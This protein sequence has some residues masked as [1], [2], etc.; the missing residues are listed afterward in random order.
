MKKK[1]G[2]SFLALALL[3]FG[4]LSIKAQS[5][6][7]FSA[8]TMVVE[9]NELFSAHVRVTGFEQIVGA[10]YS[11][12]W[13]PAVLRFL[14]VENLA[15][16][17]T[18][19]DN[20][21]TSNAEAGI[22]SF[23]WYDAAL[24]GMTLTDSTIL[25]SIRFEAVGA[26]STSTGIAFTNMPTVKEVVDM[27]FM[28]ISAGFIDGTVSI[29]GPSAANDF[30]ETIV[31]VSECQPNPFRDHASFTIHLKEAGRLHWEIFDAA[32]RS[33]LSEERRFDSGEHNLNIKAHLLDTPGAYLCRFNFN[34][35][36]VIS[37]RLIKQ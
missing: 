19:T 12:S 11:M 22:L 25:Y 37:R 9:P 6:I 16:G 5:S 31:Q 33:I 28:P 4:P 17:M 13:N 18:A 32:G 36:T 7:S 29:L 14:G 30:S 35:G 20:F 27:T 26:Q 10:Q 8:P 24:N 34:N 1:T 3:L 23:S 21:G 2:I 15:L